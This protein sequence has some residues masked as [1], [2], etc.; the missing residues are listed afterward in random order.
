MPDPRTSER[1]SSTTFTPPFPKPELKPP[2]PTID[3]KLTVEILSSDDFKNAPPEVKR[4]VLEMLE[5]ESAPPTAPAAEPATFTSEAGSRW[6][7]LLRMFG[8]GAQAL[9]G[10]VSGAVGRAAAMRA[11]GPSNTELISEAIKT[12]I[13]YT[14]GVEQPLG[15]GESVMGPEAKA[16]RVAAEAPLL[17]RLGMSIDA[18][19]GGDPTAA[20]AHFGKGETGAGLADL[21]TGGPE[22]GPA[23]EFSTE[24]NRFLDLTPAKRVNK[25]AYATG[26]TG[27]IADDLRTAFADL[28]RTAQRTGVEPKNP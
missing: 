19:L 17:P 6:S 13:R 16:R 3:S 15:P 18:L 8:L 25:L 10:D 14:L 28:K 26:G 24:L 23:M 11:G 9:T 27:T 12:P 1:R 5:E 4:R 20:A 7:N 21:F 22:L 2:K